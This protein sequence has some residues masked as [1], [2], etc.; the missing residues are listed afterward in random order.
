M[1]S[2]GLEGVFFLC[3][4]S[5]HLGFSNYFLLILKCNFELVIALMLRRVVGCCLL[6]YT[7]VVICCLVIIF[8]LLWVVLMFFMRGAVVFYGCFYTQV[9]LL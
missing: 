3:F 6:E 5:W 4:C 7:P 9:L 1:L 2:Q 8:W